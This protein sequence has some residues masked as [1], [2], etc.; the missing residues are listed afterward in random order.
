MTI[1]QAIVLGFFRTLTRAIC[2]IDDSALERIPHVG[3]LILVTNH[4]NVLEAPLLLSHLHPRPLSGFIAAYRMDSFWIRWLASTFGGVPIRRGTPD[5]KA[6]DRAIE[7]I[8][9][10]DIF[11]LTPEGTRSGDGCLQKGRPG[12]VHLALETSAPILPMVHWGSENWQRNLM[13]LRQ[14]PFH[15]EVGRTFHINPTTRN[16]R[17]LRDEVLLEIMMEMAAL[18]PRKYRGVYAHSPVRKPRHLLF[19]DSVG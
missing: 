5:R 7:R 17:A 11:G 14:T 15:I 9:A 13:G 8:E 4:V 16:T 1:Q 19:I 3:P 2:R 10:G 6:L 18:L 12:V